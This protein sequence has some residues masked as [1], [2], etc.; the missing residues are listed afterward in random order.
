MA[1]R[2]CYEVLTS[3]RRQVRTRY[4]EAITWL[5]WWAGTDLVCYLLEVT[6]HR[7]DPRRL[8]RGRHRTSFQE[9]RPAPGIP[10]SPSLSHVS[11][12]QGAW[13]CDIQPDYG[14]L[15]QAEDSHR[16]GFRSRR[17]CETQL[18]VTKDS[19]VKSLAHGEQVDIILLDFYKAFDKVP[20]QRL[21]HKLD[22]YGVRG[23]KDFLT[24]R[25]Q[26]VNLDGTSFSLAEVISGVTQGTV[27]GPLLFITYINDLPEHT[28]SEVRMF[29][30]DA[31][32]YMKIS[33]KADA[34][35]LRRDLSPLKHWEHLWQME[36]HPQKCTVIQLHVSNKRQPRTTGYTLHGHTLEEVDSAKYLGVTIYHKLRR[37]DHISN[38]RTKAN[39][40]MFKFMA[41][42]TMV[43]P[44]LEYA[45]TVWDSHHQVHIRALESI[46]R[47]A[48]R[49]VTNNYRDRTPG[50]MTTTVQELS[51]NKL[52][53]GCS[54]CSRSDIALS[55]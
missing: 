47:R 51:W 41:Y 28:K 9:R 44:T 4:Y 53:Q 36:F 43:R 48:S 37:N 2:S 18:I 5:R 16:H 26:Y 35:Q 54:W 12:M 15:W 23:I 24:T 32:L 7:N 20:H 25:T 55:T 21:L 38:I 19:I 33:S 30:D 31:L 3:T 45:N 39:R 13:T 1:L 49:F 29:A 27:L 52:Q 6:R 34:E 8:E 11:V 14:S 10:L 42:Q 22:F 17:S 50:C 46:Q 40:T